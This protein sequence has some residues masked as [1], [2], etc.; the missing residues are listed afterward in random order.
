MRLSLR[1]RGPASPRLLRRKRMV[2]VTPALLTLGNAIC[3]FACIT[4][5]ARVGPE[6]AEVTSLHFAA[7]MIFAAMAFDALDGPVARLAKLTSEFGA[8]LDSLA[9]AISFGVAPAFLMLK[10]SADVYYPH[11]RLLW[12][13]CV[14]YMLCA[15]LRLARFNVTQANDPEHETFC[16]LP[17][18]AAAGM[19]ASLVIVERGLLQLAGMEPPHPRGQAAEF[20]AWFT[21]ASLP[22]V[23]LVVACLMVSRI[24][25]PHLFNQLFHGRRNFQHLVKVLFV[26]VAVFAA[27]ELAI[28][29]LFLYFVVASPLRAFWTRVIL[30]RVPAPP[31]QPEA[32]SAPPPD[33]AAS[34]GS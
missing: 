4:Y 13:I 30:R 23:T 10:F 27:H 31:P 1:P 34:A 32:A 26:L 25:Y 5:A 19:V 14:L 21:A 33:Q 28:P 17:S 22:V 6:G 16:G 3:G 20:L 18:P 7:L 24:R 29:L 2:A 8:Q 12:V 11:A 15:V 9:D